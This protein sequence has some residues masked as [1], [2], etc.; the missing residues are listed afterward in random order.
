MTMA[1][2]PELERV[3]ADLTLQMLYLTS[4]RE[5]DIP[6]SRAW[7]GFRFE[8]LDKL[9]EGGLILDSKRAKSVHLTEEGERRT[10]ELLTEYGLAA[11]LRVG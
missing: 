6:L 8:I 5:K 10:R 11:K 3:L 2:T 9:A 1:L 7:K 4:W